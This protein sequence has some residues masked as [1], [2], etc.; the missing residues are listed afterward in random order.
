M[1]VIVAMAVSVFM[2][3]S[4]SV[5]MVVVMVVV[6]VMVMAVIV[7][8]SVV[9]TSFTMSRAF[10]AVKMNVATFTRVKNLDVDKVEDQR[11]ASDNKHERATRRVFFEEAFGGLVEKPDSKDPDRED[12]TEGTNNLHTMVT[13]CVLIVSMALSDF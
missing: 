1:A 4:V 7:I 6:V 12:R 11:Q 9:M 13:E 2:V 3:V 8:V 10:L 5:L